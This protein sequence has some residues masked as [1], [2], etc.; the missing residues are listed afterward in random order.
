MDLAFVMLLV[1]CGVCAIVYAGLAR[2]NRDSDK[3]A[4]P[5]PSTGGPDG[6][7]DRD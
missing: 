2:P 3:A 6:G 5:A 7:G 4:P 1:V